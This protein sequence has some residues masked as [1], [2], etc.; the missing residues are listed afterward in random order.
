MLE[1]SRS[2][3][4]AFGHDTPLERAIASWKGGFPF[5]PLGDP[6]K[7]IGVFEVDFSEDLCTMPS[8]QEIRN[9]RKWVTVLPGDTIQRPKV[10]TESKFARFLLH[11]KDRS[12]VRGGRLL[13]EAIVEVLIKELSEGHQLNL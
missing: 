6:D 5:I 3:G 10:H 11:K 12:S 1:S 7:M 8:V 13:N 2:V 4:E 9:E